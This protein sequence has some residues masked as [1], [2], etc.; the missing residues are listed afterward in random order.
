MA[1][2][3]EVLGLRACLAQ[4]TM[5]SGQG[6]PGNW[7][8]H[9]TDYCIQ[10]VAE[11]PYE[12]QLVV[13]TREVDHGTVTYLEKINF[14]QGNLLA[15]HSVWVSEA[16]VENLITEIGK[17][18]PADGLLPIYINPH[19]GATTS[20]PTITFGAMGDRMIRLMFN[21]EGKSKKLCFMH[22][23]VMNGG[24]MN[25]SSSTFSGYL[26]LIVLS[27]LSRDCKIQTVLG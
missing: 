5:D 16:E 2:A 10:H 7:A 15:A 13:D 4:S 24:R 6:L 23:L 25:F 1:R 22:G 9:T 3:V 21:G 18:Y 27:R 12:N 20:Y 8:L 11:I 19:T 14:L 26:A 17:N